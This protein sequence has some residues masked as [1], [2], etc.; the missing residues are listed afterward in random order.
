V[1]FRVSIRASAEIDLREARLWYEHERAGLGDDFLLSVAE[2]MTWLEESPGRFPVY[3]REFR[4]LLTGRFP[5]KIFFR[6][7]GEAVIVFRILHAA[8]DHV[9]ELK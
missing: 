1:K 3:Y 4:R 6:I 2:S 8:R 5:Y 9:R 7:D